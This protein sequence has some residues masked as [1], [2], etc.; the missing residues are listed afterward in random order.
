MSLVSIHVFATFYVGA[1]LQSLD[2]ISLA[3]L[4]CPINRPLPEN[5][6]VIDLTMTYTNPCLDQISF[7]AYNNLVHITTYNDLVH[8]LHFL[9]IYDIENLSRDTPIMDVTGVFI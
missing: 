1:I 7:L 2:F 5:I 9:Y 6:S 8:V 3:L 4:I